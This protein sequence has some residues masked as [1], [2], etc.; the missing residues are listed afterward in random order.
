[1]LTCLV[2]HNWYISQNQCWFSVL[3]NNLLE[4]VFNIFLGECLLL[5]MPQLVFIFFQ[6]LLTSNTTDCGNI[7]CHGVLV[8]VPSAELQWL[9][10]LH[11]LVLSCENRL[12]L[13][14]LLWWYNLAV[15]LTFAF[16]LSLPV[17]RVITW[18][19]RR[20][21][22]VSVSLTVLA[23]MNQHQFSVFLS[24]DIHFLLTQWS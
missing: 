19:S 15:I 12:V 8:A 7:E 18:N 14:Q 4:W 11:F 17:F 20:S 13:T 21:V 23:V 1:V 9:S 3:L 10:E 24:T 16:P 5:R 22:D 6:H 2:T